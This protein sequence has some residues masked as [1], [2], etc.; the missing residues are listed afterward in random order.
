MTADRTTTL[1][2]AAAFER[3]RAQAAGDDADWT[4]IGG[5]WVE[6]APTWREVAGDE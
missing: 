1:T 4:C 3:H 6:D 5:H 2:D